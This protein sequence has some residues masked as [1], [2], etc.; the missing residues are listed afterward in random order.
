L[1]TAGKSGVALPSFAG[2]DKSDV[3]LMMEQLEA[4][5]SD[6]SSIIAPASPESAEPAPQSNE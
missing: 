5:G 3:E 6:L 1:A 2:G 4:A